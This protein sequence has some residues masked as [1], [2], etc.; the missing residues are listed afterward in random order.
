VCQAAALAG[1]IVTQDEAGLF[2][3]SVAFGAGFSGIIPAYELVK[4]SP[5]RGRVVIPWVEDRFAGAR[6]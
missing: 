5:S 4:K 2:A 1:F 3:V 6:T